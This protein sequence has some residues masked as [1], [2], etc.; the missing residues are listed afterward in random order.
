MWW[1]DHHGAPP[2]WKVIAVIVLLISI[3]WR[4][5]ILF[6]CG[7]A[8]G[9]VLTLVI[10]AFLMAAPI[11]DEQV[12]RKDAMKAKSHFE[13]KTDSKDTE[14]LHEALEHLSGSGNS[15]FQLDPLQEAHQKAVDD[16]TEKGFSDAIKFSKERE[17]HM[18]D[19]SSFFGELSKTFTSISREIKKQ[20]ATAASKATEIKAEEDNF[21]RG[22]WLAVAD[23]LE[24]MAGDNDSVSDSLQNDIGESFSYATQVHAIATKRLQGEVAQISSDLKEASAAFEKRQKERD[25]C[26]E[27]LNS[28]YDA[29]G[30]QSSILSSLQNPTS[31]VKRHSRLLESENALTDQSM[32]LDEV[33]RIYNDTLSRIMVDMNYSTIQMSL[34]IMEG[35]LKMTNIIDNA[36]GKS[37]S[38]T[39]RL[40][41]AVVYGLM[42]GRDMS[43]FLTFEPELQKLIENIISHHNLE[44]TSS[45]TPTAVSTSSPS[46][47]SSS[48][49]ASSSATPEIAIPFPKM[50]MTTEG[51]TILAATSPVLLPH[52]PPSFNASVGSETCVWFNALTGR[53]YR[54]MGNSS[55]FADWF[56]EKCTFM[57][58][59]GKKPVNFLGDFVVANVVFGRTPPLLSNVKWAPAPTQELAPMMDLEAMARLQQMLKEVRPENVLSPREE[60][61]KKYQRG[62]ARS[63]YDVECTGDFA[64]RSGIKFQIQT[65]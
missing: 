15:K 37:K 60:Y 42:G 21:V 48:A 40:R 18:K 32:K 58:N 62:H 56:C 31:S 55:I 54:D 8:L 41:T 39:Q 22:W 28:A 63:E 10:I 11:R 33:K 2:K 65:E 30:Q 5:N 50:D 53:L 36:Y 7:L 24:Q 16:C 6:F 46:S 43:K 14:L 17:K 1:F 13:I 59:R 29:I 27:K 47:K 19:M 3:L 51:A 57:L 64:F 26:R 34:E 35:A 44:T 9:V 23:A 20:S 4:C 12:S 61:R 25:V 45:S 49:S 52:L 38:I